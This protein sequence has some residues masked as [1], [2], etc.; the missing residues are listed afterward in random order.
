MPRW[1]RPHV[2]SLLVLLSLAVVAA[3][4]AA[5]GAAT[6]D[7]SGGA[8]LAAK[9]SP[10]P[11]PCRR[12]PSRRSRPTRARGSTWRRSRCSVR[13]TTSVHASRT[14]SGPTPVDGGV[15][16]L[17]ATLKALGELQLKG[18]R[19]SLIAKKTTTSKQTL[20]V[21]AWP[22]RDNRGRLTWT[23]ARW[24]TAATNPW[25]WPSTADIQN[26]DPNTFAPE[27]LDPAVPADYTDIFGAPDDYGWNV[28]PAFSNCVW[29]ERAADRRSR[30]AGR[31]GCPR[32]SA[33][34]TPSARI[35]RAGWRSS[36]R[37]GA[38]QRQPRDLRRS[39]PR[40][41]RPR[42]RRASCGRP[43]RPR[44]DR[45]PAPPSSPAGRRTSRWP[46]RPTC[47]PWTARRRPFSPSAVA[48]S[49]SPTRTTRCPATSFRM[50]S[51]TSMSATH[52]SAC[53]PGGNRSH[54]EACRR[55]ICSPRSPGPTPGSLRS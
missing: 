49:P 51:P 29:V 39:R 41:R 1:R 14:G 34:P 46:T 4:A 3:L 24:R 53:A 38:P 12:P 25:R 23:F 30:G 28:E 40:T 21:E 27:T 31:R 37:R 5:A 47:S 50:S 6:T 2:C 26:T 9:P 15:A 11:R 13:R 33:Q 42:G 10:L 55:R 17:P 36:C 32:R 54:G 43:S 44:R 19:Q 35:L 18:I 7:G 52:S 16:K 20:T 48:A 8:V 22:I 45:P